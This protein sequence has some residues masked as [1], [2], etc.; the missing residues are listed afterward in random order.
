MR[1]SSGARTYMHRIPRPLLILSALFGCS[2][3]CQAIVGLDELRLE[4]ASGGGAAGAGGSGGNMS[5]GSASSSSSGVG[6]DGGAPTNVIWSKRFGDFAPQYVTDVEVD[7]AGNIFVVGTFQ[8]AID[9][10]SG[11]PITAS[12]D[13][14]AF[15]AKLDPDG[16]ELWS[17][18]FGAT[19]PDRIESISLTS[20]GDP[21]VGGSFSGAFSLDGAN[22][23][24]V[25]GTDG[26]I[27]KF[28]STNGALAWS[29]RF[30]DAQNQRC[31]SVT[32]IPA[33]QDV[34]CF[35][36][37]AGAINFGAMT[38]TSAGL[39]DIVLARYSATG[40]FLYAFR[41]GDAQQQTARS[42][43][44]TSSSN[45]YIAALFD[46]AIT[47]GVETI[48]S[49]G[50]GDVL[51][52]KFLMNGD[53]SW[54]M[55]MGDSNTQ[56]PNAIRDVPGGGTVMVGAFEGA[57][58]FGTKAV[59]SKGAYD[60]FVTRIDANGNAMWVRAIGDGNPMATPE[61]QDA[62]DAVATDDGSIFVTGYVSGTVDFGDG[63]PSGPGDADFFL[64]Q[65]A[66]DGQ[67]IWNIRAGSESPQ[68][69]RALALSGT[70]HL[71]VAGD[72]RGTL[73]FGNN[74]LASAGS[75]DIFIAKLNR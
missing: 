28:S 11:I 44:A 58:Q 31:S 57:G 7:A 18:R 46:G 10:G 3:G 68:F 9:F 64:M 55:R 61:D 49:A 45:L 24:H 1:A 66:P 13:Y 56:R 69:G 52:G 42:V 23:S 37:F 6:G 29:N 20:A 72:F 34:V 40:N 75:N 30:G 5:S 16:N 39:E 59:V 71:V 27:F 73:D 53:A 43:I 22:I 33:T 35:G 17:R 4:S 21:I 60:A 26:F 32:V 15:I 12:A 8:G 19:G 74:P 54:S 25:G 2:F 62:M 70:A 65:L 47:W 14:D 50:S 51:I 67:T 41:G 36:D 63:V 38:V 48:S